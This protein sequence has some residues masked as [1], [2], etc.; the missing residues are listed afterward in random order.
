MVRAEHLQ[1][2]KNRAMEYVNAIYSRIQLMTI[3]KQNV[4]PL[5]QGEEASEEFQTAFGSGCGGCL[6]EC[7]CGRIYFDVSPDGHWTWEHGELERLLEQQEQDPDQ[8]QSCNY[9]ITDMAVGGM[10][11][12]HGCHCGIAKRYEDFL[13]TY[14]RQIKEFLNARAKKLKQEA[15]DT[16]IL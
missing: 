12:V 14:V 7:A 2:C 8:Y 11:I 5:P 15:A 6:R 1:W 4:K 16:E 13:I 9:T 3:A 10:C